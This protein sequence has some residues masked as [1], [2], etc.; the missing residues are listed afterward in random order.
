M[1]TQWYYAIDG[2][3]HG[4]VGSAQLK[5]LAAS[6]QLSHAD[7]IWREGL[8]DWVEARQ[9]KAL[10]T[11]APAQPAAIRTA[12]ATATIP[13]ALNAGNAPTA[14]ALDRGDYD[15]ADEQTPPP[16]AY[17]DRP[18][19]HSVPATRGFVPPAYTP[20]T[21]T[22]QNAPLP[23]ATPVQY[24]RRGYKYQAYAGFWIRFGAIVLDGLIL[25]AAQFG[26]GFAIGLAIADGDGQ[27]TE[28]A[29][30]LLRALGVVIVW[31]Y[32]A[33]QESSSAQATIGKRA[34]GIIVTDMNGDRISFARASGRHFAKIVSNL[35][36]M[37]G[38]LMAAFTEQ[39]QAL[40]DKI[41]NCLVVQK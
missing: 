26:L 18:Y 11:A 25:V 30:L 6:G 38:Y 2:Q 7:L 41:A 23:Y 15:L 29:E 33:L 28:E 4:P 17:A 13:A 21:A 32:F 31:L 16:A 40:H 39:K 20:A 27:I 3:E 8:A 14:D 10:W 19:S 5:Q 36:L 34:C 24:Q 35:T 1:P 22:P 9:L 12:P 37:I